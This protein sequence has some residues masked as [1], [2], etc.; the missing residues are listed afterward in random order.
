MRKQFLR[1]P[2]HCLWVGCV[3]VHDNTKLLNLVWVV[4]GHEGN[5][6]KNSL[7]FHVGMCKG[8]FDLASCK[9][10]VW[11][12]WRYVLYWV[13]IFLFFPPFF[14]QKVTSDFSH[15]VISWFSIDTQA[16]PCAQ[17]GHVMWLMTSGVNNPVLRLI[18][19]MSLPRSRMTEVQTHFLCIYHTTQVLI[20]DAS[21][22]NL[23]LWGAARLLSLVFLI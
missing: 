9:G 2:S 20:N 18:W 14:K 13:Q 15:K 21:L 1:S 17:E 7:I 12:W 10:T 5:P 4:G 19:Q 3:Y 23:C 8:W 11:P 6:G 22:S 16:A